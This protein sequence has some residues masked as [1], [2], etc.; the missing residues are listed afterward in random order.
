MVTSKRSNKI[1]SKN[2][3]IFLIFKTAWKPYHELSF[4]KTSPREPVKSEFGATAA[5]FVNFFD[6]CEIFKTSKNVTMS[7]ISKNG[8]GGAGQTR[9]WIHGGL[10]RKL[11]RFL[12]FFVYFFLTFKKR[13]HELN[14]EKRVR[15]SR[16]KAN[17]E[18]RRPVSWT[19][20]IFFFWLVAYVYM[21]LQLF[22][23]F[24]GG[25]AI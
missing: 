3:F 20:S 22:V 19:F 23:P 12:W 15:G 4:A 13:H 6:F 21:H 10:F 24:P 2:V 14:L 18:P 5:C 8:T 25:W 1:T 7:L 9:I 16:S 17:L 11:F